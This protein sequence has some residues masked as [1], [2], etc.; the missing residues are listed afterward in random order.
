MITRASYNWFDKL[1]HW[2]VVLNLG[3][4]LIFSRGMSDLPLAELAVEYGD[5]GLSVMTLLI[6][7]TIRLVWRLS[8]P[9]PA[10]PETMQPWER[11]SAKIVH[12]GLYGLI[13]LQ[14]SIGLLLASTTDTDFIANGYGINFTAFGLMPDTTHDILLTLHKIVYWS[15]VS[16]IAIHVLAALKHAF[17]NR[18]RVLHRMLPFV[19]NV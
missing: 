17:I 8:H 10:L 12:W 7:M 18:D 2:F 1:L 14:I 16:F 13:F 15:I 3:L 4:T 11:L 6:V 19:R 5:H 9:A